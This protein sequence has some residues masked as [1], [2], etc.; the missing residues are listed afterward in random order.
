MSGGGGDGGGHEVVHL[1]SGGDGCG[2]TGHVHGP[3]MPFV[4]VMDG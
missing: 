2:A 4:R 1:S 3:L